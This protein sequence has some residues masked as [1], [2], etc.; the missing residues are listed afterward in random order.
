MSS[1]HC[2]IA[3]SKKQLDDALRLRFCVFGEE[4]GLLAG[5]NPIPR[6]LDSFDTLESTVHFLAYVEGKAAGT[7]RLLLP[8]AEIA[9]ASGQR[10]GFHLEHYFD[11]SAMAQSNIAPAELTRF[12]IQ[13]PYRR[14]PLLLHLYEA[15]RQESLRRGITHWIASAN[16][17]T[18]SMEDA[19]IMG[20]VAESIG[21]C[22]GVRGIVRRLS[23]AG[24][25]QPRRPFYSADERSRAYAGK[26]SGL[27]LPKPLQSFSKLGAR[28]VSAPIYDSRF[29]SCSMPL[30]A[31]VNRGDAGV[32][33]R[34]Q[35]A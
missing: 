13:K 28:F 9:Q 19:L 1:I 33:Q 31:E 25:Q 2:C 27:A 6:E 4:L 16:T 17:E 7:V 26:L 32:W 15:M 30:V 14:S 21:L 20:A 11:L 12:C 8:N 18:D 35:A 24:P 22:S 3:E 5:S 10:F 34:P 29:Q 23:I